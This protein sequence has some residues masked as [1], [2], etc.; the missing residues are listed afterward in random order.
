MENTP[1]VNF[2]LFPPRSRRFPPELAC[3]KQRS[4]DAKKYV[5][6]V[7]FFFPSPQPGHSSFWIS[8]AKSPNSTAARCFSSP[9]EMTSATTRLWNGISST[10]TTRSCLTTWILTP[11]CTYKWENDLS[12]VTNR[13]AFFHCVCASQYTALLV[14]MN[15]AV[16]FLTCWQNKESVT[17]GCLLQKMPC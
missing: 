14:I 1:R 8:T 16:D 17:T 10:S 4:L 2:F 12:T 15:H 6:S 5:L 13:V 7:I 11:S 3:A 9:W